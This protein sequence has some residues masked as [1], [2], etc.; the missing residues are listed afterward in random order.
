LKDLLA[1][2]RRLDDLDAAAPAHAA[3]DD[4]ELLLRLV[5]FTVEILRRHPVDG[6]GRCRCCR[7]SRSGCRRWL[8]WPTRKAPCLVLSVASFYAT[9]PAEHVWFQALPHLGV[10]RELRDIRARLAYPVMTAEP[11]PEPVW[12]SVDEPTQPGMTTPVPTIP[13]PSADPSNG[14]HAL[15]V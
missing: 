14:R 10:H 11:E 9:V 3:F 7:P 15:I 2:I 12:P 1:T 4:N 13:M 6:H 5:C 8:R